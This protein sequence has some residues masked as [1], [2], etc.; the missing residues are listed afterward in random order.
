[1]RRNLARVYVLTRDGKI[2]DGF[3]TLSATAIDPS[4]LPLEMARKLPG[5]PIPATLLGRMAVDVRMQGHR[6]GNLIMVNALRRAWDGSRIIGSWA[7][8]VDAKESARGFYLK[9]GFRPFPDQPV[10]L[11]LTM[12]RFA[13]LVSGLS[14]AG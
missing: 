4:N 5:F 13:Q 8:V 11:F 3:Y 6:L 10:R 2:V 14:I 9:H 1:M 7:V 12:D